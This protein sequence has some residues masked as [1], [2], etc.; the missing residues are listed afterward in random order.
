MFTINAM[1]DSPRGCPRRFI[2][3]LSWNNS[4]KLQLQIVKRISLT[5][6]SCAAAEICQKDSLEE[7][8]QAPTEGY[9]KLDY[10]PKVRRWKD[11]EGR[12]GQ[13]MHHPRRHL[14]FDWAYYRWSA[15]RTHSERGGE[16]TQGG[17]G[18]WMGLKKILSVRGRRL[19]VSRAPRSPAPNLKGKEKELNEGSV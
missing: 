15:S 6:L 9:F 16:L 18:F 11:L 14:Y 10:P 12:L 4:N 13:P 17:H 5:K 7:S 1:R 3:Y 19:R 8:V 2:Q